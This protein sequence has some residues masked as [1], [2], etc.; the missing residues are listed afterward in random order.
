[1]TAAFLGVWIAFIFK[2]SMTYIY[3]L[4]II[5]DKLFDMDLI[6]ASDYTCTGVISKKMW[7]TFC[8]EENF[9]AEKI[10]TNLFITGMQHGDNE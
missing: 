9:N 2:H 3:S 6:T 1:M 10:I 8:E 7:Q 5:N 4:D